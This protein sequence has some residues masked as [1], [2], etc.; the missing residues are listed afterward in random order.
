LAESR[1]V[2]WRCRRKADIRI[3]EIGEVS[4]RLRAHALRNEWSEEDD[5]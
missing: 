1:R 2:R 3:G 5:G 4:S